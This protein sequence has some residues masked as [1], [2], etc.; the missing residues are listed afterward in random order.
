M[1]N[2]F[3]VLSLESD[4]TKSLLTWDEVG[5]C[6]VNNKLLVLTNFAPFK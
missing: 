5:F 1:H 3:T 4:S 2:I 6:Q